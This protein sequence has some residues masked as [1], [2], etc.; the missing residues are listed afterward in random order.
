MKSS[1]PIV[2]VLAGIAVAAMLCVCSI[3]A[4]AAGMFLFSDEINSALDNPLDLLTEFN[5]GPTQV[6][7]PLSGEN[8]DLEKLFAPMWES[9]RYL[10]N[11]FVSQPVDDEVLAEGAL[12]GLLGYLEEQGVSLDALSVT[13][14]SP[15]AEA[16]AAEAETPQE[17][18]AAFAPFWEAWHT[19]QFSQTEVSGSYQDLLR[20]SLR[21]MVEALGDPHTAYMDPDQLRQ[22]NISLDGEYE[23]I[24]AYVDTTT[25][26][27]TIVTPISGSPAEAAGLRPG[28]QVLAVD[29]TDMTGIP[30]DAVIG[31]ILGPEG[32][33]VT[34]TIRREGEPTFDVTIVRAHISIPSVEG[35]ML[36]E[37]IAYI[38]LNTFGANTDREMRAILE[39]LLAQ[40]PKGL[41]LDLR[42]NGGGY[43]NTAVSLTSE[44]LK[45]GIVLIEEYGNGERDQY[46]V[47]SGGLATEIPMVVLVNNGSASA[48][49]I[50]AGALQDYGRAPL[51]GETTFGK[52]SVQTPATLSNGEGALRITIAHWLTSK[53]R[54]IHGV[55]LE[56]DYVVALTEEDFA[57]DLDPQ[58]DKAIELINER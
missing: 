50:L 39:D 11:D 37:G 53:D 27:V 7:Q 3:G 5:A 24:G 45:E 26:Y 31:Y 54:L 52:G 21:S 36:D 6:P 55:G 14:G 18:Q 58:L 49:E 34:L 23:G 15:S 43:L 47:L 40:N 38:Q 42:N 19:V 32:T 46:N 48:S 30:G 16:L 51:V 44:F 1:R 41:I 28:D 17:A 33:R 13:A 8:P 29:G 4:V 2:Y 56:P 9:R 10:R 25:E 35:E 57:Q 20:A 22:S 12:D